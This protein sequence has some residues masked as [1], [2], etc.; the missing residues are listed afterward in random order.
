MPTKRNIIATETPKYLKLLT[1]V[2]IIGIVPQLDY[3]NYDEKTLDL[4]SRKIQL[5]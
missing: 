2:P 3:L 5:D 4:V 1:K